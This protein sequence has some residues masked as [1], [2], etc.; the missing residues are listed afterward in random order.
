MFG[1]GFHLVFS[2]VHD[3]VPAVAAGAL[4]NLGP[5]RF[6]PLALTG[7]HIPQ[8]VGGERVTPRRAGLRPHNGGQ[9]LDQLLHDNHHNMLKARSIVGLSLPLSKAAMIGPLKLPKRSSIRRSSC[10]YL[11]AYRLPVA[12]D[13]NHD[14]LQSLPP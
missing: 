6:A 3:R 1:P 11:K 7:D 13:V 4:L 10:E 9:R 12:A 14:T 5:D 8:M 2:S